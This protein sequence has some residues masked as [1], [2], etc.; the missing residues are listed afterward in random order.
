MDTGSV[1]VS[2]ENLDASVRAAIYRHFADEATT[3]L[4]GDI[5]A[6]LG[7]T[8][9]ETRAAMRRLA[10][11][12]ALTLRADGELLMAH[13]FSAVPTGYRVH[14]N[15][16]SWWANC[17]WDALGFAS[18]LGIDVRVEC[19]CPDCREPMQVEVRNGALVDQPLRMHFALPPTKWWDDIVFT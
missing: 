17:A 9:D 12:K 15:G 5:A 8:S 13:P 11:G 19:A 3:P 1:S 14:G 6:V 10:A 4:A 16:K 2:E 18:M 7:L